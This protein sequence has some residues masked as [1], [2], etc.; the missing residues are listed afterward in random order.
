MSKLKKGKVISKKIKT[1]IDQEEKLLEKI[2]IAMPNETTSIKQRM[3]GFR[4]Y[5]TKL[6]PLLAIPETPIKKL[7]NLSPYGELFPS[8]VYNM[9][10]WMKH[11]PNT[12]KQPLDK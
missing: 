6:A 12:T 2:K 4:K 7:S 1:M 3:K 9:Q 11:L 10:I 8:M 5:P